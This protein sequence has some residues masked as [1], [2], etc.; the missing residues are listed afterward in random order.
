MEIL[1][2]V[3]VVDVIYECGM[4]FENMK[5]LV[6]YVGLVGDDEDYGCKIG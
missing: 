5:V 4:F 2:D 1:S 6:W 3:G